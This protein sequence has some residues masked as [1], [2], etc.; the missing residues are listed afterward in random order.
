M[1]G[2]EPQGSFDELF[3]EFWSPILAFAASRVGQ[4]DAQDVAQEVFAVVDRRWNDVPSSQYER[5]LWVFG[6][7]KKVCQNRQR[8]GRRFGR[9]VYKVASLDPRPGTYEDDYST[10]EIARELLKA[11]SLRS[12]DDAE[13]LL[14]LIE[15]RSTSEIAS[16][17]GLTETAANSRIHRLRKHL[18]RE[19]P[20][21]W[22][23]PPP[24][25]EA[26]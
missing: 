22:D 20:D 24:V 14:L 21:F 13:L 6:V 26:T 5:R 17:L 1:P 23:D 3:A 12:E 16:L 8:G 10:V 7:A 2:G 15:E 11:I 19:I 4:D 18:R 9:M 25:E